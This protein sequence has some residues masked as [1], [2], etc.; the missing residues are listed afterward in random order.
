MTSRGISRPNTEQLHL[1]LDPSLEASESSEEM[2]TAGPSSHWTLSAATPMEGY[3]SPS[4]VYS[5]SSY[6]SVSTHAGSSSSDYPDARD[7]PRR[8]A[9][10]PPHQQRLTHRNSVHMADAVTSPPILVLKLYRR[11]RARR[12]AKKISEAAHS[13]TK[14]VGKFLH[15]SGHSDEI[16]PQHTPPHVP[17]KLRRPPARRPPPVR[18]PPEME[19]SAPFPE[20]DMA[21]FEPHPSGNKMT[22]A[23]TPTTRAWHL[24]AALPRKSPRANRGV[25][26]SSPF[27]IRKPPPGATRLV[28]SPSSSVSTRRRAPQ[29]RP[30]GPRTS[31]Y[32]NFGTEGGATVVRQIR[33]ANSE[34]RAAGLPGWRSS[35]YSPLLVEGQSSSVVDAKATIV[36]GKD[37]PFPV[38]KPGYI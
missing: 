1:R 12:T 32:V 22:A 36:R 31:R 2:T 34:N 27:P 38:P 10:L 17:R 28:P 24:P 20:G 18:P 3:P 4:S 5:R 16:H 13:S 29:R 25:E 26:I 8:H 37:Q 30:S 6:C 19:I 15:L 11:T 23:T 7:D 33:R 9:F 35:E 21:G 14:A